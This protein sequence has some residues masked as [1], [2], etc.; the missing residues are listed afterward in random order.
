MMDPNTAIEIGETLGQVSVT[1]NAK[2][3]VGGTFL[4]VRVEVVISEP[5][6]RDM[7]K[8]GNRDNVQDMDSKSLIP[9]HHTELIG[10]YEEELNENQNTITDRVQLSEFHATRKWKRIERKPHMHSQSPNLHDPTEKKRARKDGETG[11]QQGGFNGGHHVEHIVSQKPIEI[12]QGSSH[13][14]VLVSIFLK[15]LELGLLLGERKW[16][17]NWTK[18]SNI[19]RFTVLLFAG[20]TLAYFSL[21]SQNWSGAVSSSLDELNF[22]TFSSSILVLVYTTDSPGFCFLIIDPLFSSPPPPLLV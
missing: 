10:E 19:I 1:E 16:A 2:E 22:T 12:E 4:R 6:C 13:I 9:P 17:M 15:E 5:L 14:T 8:K 11:L 20:M 18:S 21:L 7:H 3:M